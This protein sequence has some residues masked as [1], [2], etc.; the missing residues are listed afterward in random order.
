MKFLA[1][2]LIQYLL[3]FAMPLYAQEIQVAFDG[4]DRSEESGKILIID[5]ELRD[6]LSI[7]PEYPGFE[8]ARLF[9]ASERHYT[10]EVTYDDAGKTAR[11]IS[12]IDSAQAS[13]LRANIR[14]RII[15]ERPSALLDQSGRNHLL[16]TTSV[17]SFYYYGT[18][19]SVFTER[20]D[21][22]ILSTTHLLTG[23]IGFFLPYLLT[24]N[25]TV[26]SGMA[27]GARVGSILGIV[28]GLTATQI[29]AD[30]PDDKVVAAI[31]GV[32]SLAE[33][34]AGMILAK[35]YDVPEGRVNLIGVGGVF[36]TL[37]G[38]EAATLITGEFGRTNAAIGLIGSVAT[39]YGANELALHTNY[40]TG[41]AKA[42]MMGGLIGSYL[43]SALTST[44]RTP[45]SRAGVALLMGGNILG[46]ALA[47]TWLG[48]RD[49]TDADGNYA[50]LGGIG[51]SL[52]GMAVTSRI[53][54]DDF[55]T[56]VTISALGSLAGYALVM[57]TARGDREKDKSF[58]EESDTERSSW[59]GRLELSADPISIATLLT[60]SGSG[61]ISAKGTSVPVARV[62]M[63]L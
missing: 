5:R 17:V 35:K 57:A 6:Q 18:V 39:M 10:L 55:Q 13:E 36:G 37:L 58:K 32:L 53:D 27:A 54:D 4:D 46:C 29:V 1:T 14:N 61:A 7:F 31:G 40:T 44:I 42:M 48:Q 3:A 34:G 59:L 49:L 63:S 16:W 28:H 24:T 22:V 38:V 23:G 30:S 15:S 20:G 25:A 60:S 9:R 45:D 47:H 26:T 56:A 33:L 12:P 19:L 41:D 11:K 52:L 51:G 50:V 43:A 2:I 8:Q 21:N 62:R